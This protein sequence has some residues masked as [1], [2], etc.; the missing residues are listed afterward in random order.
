M[1]SGFGRVVCWRVQRDIFCRFRIARG[2]GPALWVAC[3]GGFVERV[4]FSED[5]PVIA[6][7]ALRL[8]DDV[9]SA[10]AVFL[11][12]PAYELY[13]PTVCGLDVREGLVRKGG[14]V[15]HRFE[16][17][18]RDTHLDKSIKAIACAY[19]WRRRRMTGRSA[20]GT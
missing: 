15:L 4:S 14:P 9:D 1:S 19:G 5:G 20:A 13:H 10:V 7:V 12:V 16:T 8:G 3:F 17:E 11:V 18:S 6:V 2:A